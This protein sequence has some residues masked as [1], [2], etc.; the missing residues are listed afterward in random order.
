LQSEFERQR[1]FFSELLA[2][3]R[4]VPGVVSAAGITRRPLGGTG[5]KVRFALSDRPIPDPPASPVATRRT[6]TPDLFATLGMRLIRGRGFTD[7]DRGGAARVAVVSESLMRTHWGAENPIGHRL[8]MKD[9]T[10][11]DDWREIVGVVD[12]VA[13]GSPE[14]P[15][16]HL[17]YTPLAQSP[18]GFYRNWGMD[19]MVR[20]DGRDAVVGTV[21][22][23]IETVAP[24][25][26]VFS[27]ASMETMLGATHASRRFSLVLISLFGLVSA[28]LAAV[29][30]YGVMAFSVSR[31]THE[32]GIRMV[33][34]ARPT[35]VVR[36][37]LWQ[38]AAMA[39]V[40]V[41]LG[42]AGALAV[43]R[44]LAGMLY[45]VTPTD[46]PTFLGVGLALIVLALV[47]C[48][49]PALRAA[50]VDPLVAVHE[51]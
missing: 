18:A 43:T 10:D 30:I 17:I 5:F 26:P 3:V 39:L 22:E 33:L 41:L 1:L 50:R 38:G 28:L 11:P 49:L 14:G 36:M 35:S 7:A 13:F 21:R 4:E 6:V 48:G 16:T 29:G 47:A 31:R 44:F 34:G 20:T 45:N 2:G 37:V 23:R 25:L 27:V 24:E 9:P 8:S 40:G 46:P 15:P 32:L 12:D 51:E 19:L 42:T